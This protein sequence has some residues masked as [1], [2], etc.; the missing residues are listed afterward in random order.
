M[1]GNLHIN[2][3]T[4]LLEI[5]VDGW[6][7]V[8]DEFW[9]VKAS[10]AVCRQL[11]HRRSLY[12]STKNYHDNSDFV[13]DSVMCSRNQFYFNECSYETTHNCDSSEHVIVLCDTGNLL[14]TTVYGKRK[15]GKNSLFVALRLNC[16]YKTSL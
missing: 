15:K 6:A 11:G 4:G 9:D 8:C 7:Y 14:H 10:D 5:Y 12:T 3:E 16:S 1:D 2:T 13:I